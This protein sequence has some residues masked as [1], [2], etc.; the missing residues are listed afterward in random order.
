MLSGYILAALIWLFLI[1][2][3]VPVYVSDESKRLREE[4]AVAR[5]RRR[6]ERKTELKL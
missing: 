5:A 1:L 4:E 6:E 3:F 2:K